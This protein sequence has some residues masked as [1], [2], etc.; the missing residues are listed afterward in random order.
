MEDFK[1]ELRN[2]VKEYEGIRVVNDVSLT[3]QS[4]QVYV[5]LGSNGAGK[6]TL[7]EI[8]CGA[9]KPDSGTLLFNGKTVEQDGVLSAKRMGIEMCGREHMNFPNLSVAENIA[10]INAS[11]C[12]YTSV[13]SRRAAVL[14]NV[15]SFDAQEK[16]YAAVFFWFSSYASARLFTF[17]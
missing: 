12:G 17:T 16:K 11:R 10:L 9:V 6:S 5:L 15:Y 14:E 4:G 1:F 13:Y 8:I 7:A 3:L 2:I